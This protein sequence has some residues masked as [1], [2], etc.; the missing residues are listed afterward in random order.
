MI[1]LD[2]IFDADDFNENVRALEL[3]ALRPAVAAGIN[4]AAEAVRLD[5]IVGVEESLENPT[6]F[7]LNAFG[8]IPAD[9]AGAKDPAALVAAK[10]RQ[11]QFLEL[12]IDGGV[13]RAG[14]YATASF[15][16]I[17][18]GPHAP[19]D[20]Y[21]NL[22]RGYISRQLTDPHVSWTM[23]RKAGHP[24]L[25]RNVPGGRPEILAFLIPEIEY[26]PT[27]DFYGIV[28]A[29][30]QRHLTEEVRAALMESFAEY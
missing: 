1:D 28:Q 30:A 29:S 21:G 26:E 23:M 9:T 20:Q 14:D 7:T 3:G 13:R 16:S 22:P 24:A 12:Q 19:K 17:V 18:P 11:A 5:L 27:F 15:G 6:P 25:V 2:I 10:P 4:A 8:V